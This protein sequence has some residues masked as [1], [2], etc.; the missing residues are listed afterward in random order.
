[1]LSG[2]MNTSGDKFQKSKWCSICR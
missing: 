1:M 2:A